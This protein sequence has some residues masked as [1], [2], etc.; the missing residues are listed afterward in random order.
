MDRLTVLSGLS[1]V[2]LHPREISVLFRRIFRNPSR[3]ADGNLELEHV[4]PL[5]GL[6]LKEIRLPYFPA[7]GS[8]DRHA[9]GNLLLLFPEDPGGIQSGQVMFLCL[10]I[11][12]IHIHHDGS[13]FF[14]YVPAMA[15][16]EPA[17]NIRGNQIALHKHD[18]SDAGVFVI[19]H[20]VQVPGLDHLLVPAVHLRHIPPD[21]RRRSII[22]PV[23]RANRHQDHI[24]VPVQLRLRVHDDPALHEPPGQKHLILFHA[25]LLSW[26]I[27]RYS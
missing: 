18:V 12:R 21:L 5:F 13:R 23:R 20:L 27:L 15:A 22:R 24:A 7:H 25:K 19:G 4:R 8:Q 16:F 17:V 26:E 1:T 9:V 10:N 14:L 6:P 11:D 3:A 2:D